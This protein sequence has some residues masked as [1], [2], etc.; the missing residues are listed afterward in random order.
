[1]EESCEESCGIVFNVLS[2]VYVGLSSEAVK[3]NKSIM[4]LVRF[5]GK[6]DGIY[7]QVLNVHY[8]VMQYNVSIEHSDS[9]NNMK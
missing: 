5:C 2:L 1:M 3:V 6:S 8:E 7:L 4:I 9:Y